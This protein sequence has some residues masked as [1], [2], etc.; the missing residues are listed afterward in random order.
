V[1]AQR[2]PWRRTVEA[3][4]AVVDLR[5]LNV[6]GYGSRVLLDVVAGPLPTAAHLNAQGARRLAHAL[7][8]AARESEVAEG[9]R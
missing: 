7:L 6:E 8:A 5:V 9:K 2:A 1:S 3:V 4:N